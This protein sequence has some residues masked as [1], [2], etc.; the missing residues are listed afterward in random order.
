MALEEPH[1]KGVTRGVLRFRH[2]KAKAALLE[3]RYSLFGEME[4][5]NSGKN[6]KWMNGISE[7]MIE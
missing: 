4:R 2:R 6:K 3:N 1:A 5:W 7:R